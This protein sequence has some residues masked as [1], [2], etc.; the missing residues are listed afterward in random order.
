MAKSKITA[1]D[2][3][4]QLPEDHKRIAFQTF[5]FHGER[6]LIRVRVK[7]LEK[8]KPL[9][10]FNLDTNSYISSLFPVKN[11]FVFDTKDGDQIKKYI[12]KESEQGLE[13]NK[14]DKDQ[15]QVV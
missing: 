15:D 2:I 12:L 4:K 14:C 13:V 7:G 11:G 10:L 8:K 1:Q 9:F 3:L 6:V 5:L